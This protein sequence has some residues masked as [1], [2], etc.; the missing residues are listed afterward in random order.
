MTKTPSDPE[1]FNVKAITL[2]EKIKKNNLI[3]RRGQESLSRD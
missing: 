1:T 2:A 3:A